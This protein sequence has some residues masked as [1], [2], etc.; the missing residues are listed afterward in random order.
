M[1]DKTKLTATSSTHSD[2]R[3]RTAEDNLTACLEAYDQRGEDGLQ[4]ELERI[5][6]PA[7]KRIRFGDGK[8][9][10]GMTASLLPTPLPASAFATGLDPAPCDQPDEPDTFAWE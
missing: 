10:P 9:F 6:P 1:A 4:E 2:A 8:M 5:H 3:I 7:L